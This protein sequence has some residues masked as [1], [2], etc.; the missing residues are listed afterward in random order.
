MIAR[1]ILI[2]GASGG[3]GAALA[4]VYAVPGSSFVLWGRN[5][6]RL[7]ETAAQCR[8]RG[9]LC[10]TA[11]FDLTDFDRL[12]AAL[13]AADARNP[14]D[15]VIL[16][17]GV[18]GSLPRDRAAQDARLAQIMTGVNFTAPVIAANLLADRMAR[19]GRG[20]IV[21]VGSVAGSF[22]LPMAPVYSGTKAGLAMFAEA[23]GLRLARYGVGVTLV[24]P[25]FVDTAMSRSLKEPRPFLMTPDAAAAI[26][27]R[28]IECGARHIVVPWQFA[29]ILAAAKLVPRS[30]MR[31]VFSRLLRAQP[32]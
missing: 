2:T 30:I 1:N 18:G 23:M 3:I 28:K 14:F 27:A 21:F 6:E 17:A 7:A 31:A 19:R 22:P 29:V 12:V 4:R 20:R 11:S 26:I 9:A 16:N 32:D 8:A 5:E 24:S 25:G 13:E 15:L 10:E